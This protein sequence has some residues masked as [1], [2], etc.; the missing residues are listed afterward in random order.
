MLGAAAGKVNRDVRMESDEEEEMADNNII[1]WPKSYVASTNCAS[2]KHMGLMTS[3]LI[4]RHPI[5]C[6]LLLYFCSVNKTR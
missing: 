6:L 4:V 5:K 3:L 1:I 2:A